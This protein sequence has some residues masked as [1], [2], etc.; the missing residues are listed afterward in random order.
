MTTL[1]RRVDPGRYRGDVA[2]AAADGP[3]NGVQG[4]DAR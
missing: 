4:G 3:S 1:S 2:G